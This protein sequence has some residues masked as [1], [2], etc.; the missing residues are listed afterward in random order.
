MFKD[1][2]KD[3]L[4]Q[5]EF[6][7]LLAIR[8]GDAL[9]VEKWDGPGDL[10]LPTYAV[11]LFEAPDLTQLDLSISPVCKTTGAV[12]VGISADG[13]GWMPWD[14]NMKNMVSDL[15]DQAGARPG[16]WFKLT[17]SYVSPLR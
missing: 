10:S 14:V 17:I 3:E 1:E 15:L 2:L 9:S 4:T 16:E 7:P 13:W 11:A 8:T 5:V 12:A 6:L